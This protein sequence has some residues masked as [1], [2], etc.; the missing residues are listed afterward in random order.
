MVYGLNIRPEARS[1]LVTAATCYEEIDADLATRLL[2]SFQTCIARLMVFPLTGHVVYRDIRRVVLDRFP[3]SVLY[4]VS[5]TEV[6][7]VAM[8]HQRR[9][10]DQSRQTVLGR[11]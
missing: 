7:V 2:D 6:F 9:D 4:R 11:G 1:D 5:G 3:C 8:I 10:P